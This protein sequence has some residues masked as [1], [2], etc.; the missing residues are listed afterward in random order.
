MHLVVPIQYSRLAL[1]EDPG[2]SGNLG[3]V[4]RRRSIPDPLKPLDA[5]TWLVTRNA[6]SA[7]LEASPLAPH[8]DLRAILNTARQQ[9][10]ADGW[11]CEVI[12]RCCSFFFCKRDG[13]R[14]IV[15]VERHD[16]AKPYPGHR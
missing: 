7:V 12:G 14:V 13:V 16:P 1:A 8:T 3:A 5:P 11:D 2:P 10:I 9:R 6:W 4:V 15:N